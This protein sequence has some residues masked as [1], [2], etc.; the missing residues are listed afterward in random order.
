MKKDF[1][2]TAQVETN[3]RSNHDFEKNVQNKTAGHFQAI[4]NYDGFIDIQ[5]KTKT[6][7]NDGDRNL[8]ST[9]HFAK[10]VR[11]SV[12]NNRRKNIFFLNASGSP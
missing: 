7:M 2:K 4:L 12:E 1:Q 3:R 10:E 9:Q 6:M 8:I 11:V 5:K